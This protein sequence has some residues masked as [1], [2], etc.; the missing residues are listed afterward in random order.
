M[1]LC[2][3]WH[4]F[5]PDLNYRPLLSW[6]L[7]TH[8]EN[9]RETGQLKDAISNA[10]EA[11]AVCRRMAGQLID[12]GSKLFW[13]AEDEWKAVTFLRALF[14]LAAAHASADRHLAA[15]E[16]AKE[17]FQ[18]VLRFPK[19]N[20][21]PSAK[22]IDTFIDQ[23]CKVAEG[24]E[25]SLGMLAENVIMFRDLARP[26]PPIFSTPFLHILHAYAYL[27]QQHPPDFSNLRLFLE[28]K[29]G[30]PR[31]LDTFSNLKVYIED[32]NPYGGIIEDVIRAYPWDSKED[33]VP[34][35]KDI[36]G[37]HFH[38]ATR[39][40]HQMISKLMTDP[41]S[42]PVILEWVLADV[43]FAIL[44]L[45]T[46]AQQ[47]VLMEIM[48]KVVGHLRTVMPTPSFQT[49]SVLWYFSCGLWTAGLLNEVMPIIDEAL[50]YRRCGLAG[51]NDHTEDWLREWIVN[52]TFVL[53]DMCRIPEAIAA[54]QEAR[55][56]FA[57]DTD[58][59]RYHAIRI[60]LVQRTGRDREAIQLLRNVVSE[61]GLFW[62][63]D[64]V[65]TRCYTQILLADLAEIRRRTGQFRNALTDA[66]RAVAAGR[67][68][69]AMKHESMAPAERSLVHALSTL[70]N[71]LAAVGRNDEALA[72]SEESTSRY[73][74][75]ASWNGLY[76]L[77]REEL[78]ANAFGALSLRL[79]TSGQL[80]A[81][82]LNAEK[83]IELY[84][85]SVSLTPRLL[86]TLASSLKNLASI[87]WNA[88]RRDE[89]ISACDEAVSIMRNVADNETYFLGALGEALDQLARYL[90]EKGYTERATAATSESGGV[91]NKIA[92]L[93]P[94][95]EFLCSD[96][97]MDESEDEYEDEAWETAMESEDDN[98]QDAETDI[99]LKASELE[100]AGVDLASMQPADLPPEAEAA[101][102]VGAEAS[103][104]GSKTR[105]IT[106]ALRV[107]SWVAQEFATE[108]ARPA[109]P[110]SPS[111]MPPSSILGGSLLARTRAGDRYVVSSTSA[112]P[113][114]AVDGS[115]DV[116]RK[117]AQKRRSCTT[118][119][120]HFIADVAR[121]IRDADRHC[122]PL[123]SSS[124]IPT[125]RKSHSSAGAE[126]WPFLGPVPRTCATPTASSPLA[127][128]DHDVT[129]PPRYRDWIGHP[130]LSSHRALERLFATH[131]ASQREVAD[132][133][134]AR[135]HEQARIHARRKSDEIGDAGDASGLHF[136]RAPP[137]SAFPTRPSTRASPRSFQGA[138]SLGF[139]GYLA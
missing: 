45:V 4:E 113:R 52:R 124:C 64:D 135:A 119:R 94:E 20:Y 42:D 56:I 105:S 99:E 12:S 17:G 11:V 126:S 139:R 16:A 95:P 46:R 43:V 78:G 88:G 117:R 71:C 133:H 91:R 110:V 60:R 31:P 106:D 21:P 92:L 68:D 76:A 6:I 26:Y 62:T 114:P 132:C 63:E 79:A 18:T 127:P 32:F 33:V 23:L 83:A 111:G 93:P 125:R 73:K 30:S 1:D 123:P 39:A 24:G 89:C 74:L 72:A 41:H 129:C 3:M 69:V 10:E 13:T 44:P 66:E 51:D 101:R 112:R 84:R 104:S 34:L 61:V 122:F 67:K 38:Q 55:P 19:I 14:A 50:E 9:F 2:R 54:A 8:S 5:S 28:P 120:K 115:R 100:G 22:T 29:S 116:R 97:E 47:L 36:F 58:I 138:V 128:R 82:L 40:I 77:R 130:L 65:D 15:Y 85:E 87:L 118:I 81:A 102:E 53:C 37:T 35:I 48:M 70:S 98:Y 131:D 86:P 75:S 49:A 103:T 108:S 59:L 137:A 25:F 136:A 7:I 57:L 96:V 109:R 134:H 121:W 107:A 90:D 27:R 80:E